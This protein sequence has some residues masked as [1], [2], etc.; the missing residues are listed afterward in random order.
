MEDSK[1]PIVRGL[2]K[3]RAPKREEEDCRN[4][5]ICRTT[6]SHA[7]PNREARVDEGSSRPGKTLHLDTLEYSAISKGGS[8][9]CIAIIDEDSRKSWTE[10][11][12]TKT[13]E[14]VLQKAL[15]VINLVERET[16]RK[17][18]TLHMDDGRE[19]MRLREY[20]EEQGIKCEISAPYAKEQNG[21]VERLNRTLIER[22]RSCLK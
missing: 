19:F 16:G 20:A 15:T 5:E 11:T 13:A 21:L 2:G 1:W 3:T 12:K 17:V 4:C 7:T 10:Y 18:E 9:Y 14:E 6:K 22:T 8:R